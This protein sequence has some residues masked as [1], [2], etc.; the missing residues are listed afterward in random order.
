MNARQ[1]EAVAFDLT[2]RR[3]RIREAVAGA[4]ACMILALV[5]APV[6]IGMGAA[7]AA[8]AVAG[9]LLAMFGRLS[10][11]DQIARLAVDPLA[12]QLPEVSRYANRLTSRRERE[13]LAAWIGEI[14]GE[15]AAI[16][17]HW[18]LGERVLHYAEE[19]AALGRDLCDPQV[20]IPPASAA[21]AHRLLTQAADSPL[22]NPSVSADR[23]P[24]I[25]ASIR[26]GITRYS[27]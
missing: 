1:V 3:K 15:A 2:R 7:F 11:H 10:R 14:L 5:S 26:L 19:L 6:A 24:A 9:V 8:G 27:A 12:H 22:Y 18:Y 4:A 25:I 23:L 13:R 16:P 17:G 20:D 21:A